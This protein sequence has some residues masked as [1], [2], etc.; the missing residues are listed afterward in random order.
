[1]ASGMIAL[2]IEIELTETGGY[3]ATSPVLHGSLV[4]GETIEEVYREA[5]VAAQSLLEAL[6]PGE[7]TGRNWVETTRPTCGIIQ[8]T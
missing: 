2:P 4:E 1:M 8:S 7:V 3:L 5:R 6:R